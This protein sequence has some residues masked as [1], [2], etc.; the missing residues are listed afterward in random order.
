M[1]KILICDYDTKNLQSCAVALG[2]YE[3]ITASNVTDALKVYMHERP[4][5]VLWAYQ[6]KDWNDAKAVR[7]MNEIAITKMVLMVTTEL[8]YTVTDELYAHGIINHIM[9]KPIMAKILGQLVAKLLDHCP[10]CDGDIMGNTRELPCSFCH[11]SGRYTA[12]GYA[13]F[14][15][16]RCDCVD[17]RCDI[18]RMACHH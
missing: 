18:C 1:A 17:D 7:A 3:V 6:L 14:K 4:E 12:Q 8:E 10:I 15:C 2:S 9:V 11:G 5:L 16:H 13:Y